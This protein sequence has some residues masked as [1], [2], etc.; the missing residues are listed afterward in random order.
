VEAYCKQVRLL[1]ERLDYGEDAK[2]HQAR[3]LILLADL[4]HERENARQCRRYLEEARQ[5]LL[6]YNG[7]D[8]RMKDLLLGW[9]AEDREA[10]RPVLDSNGKVLMMRFLPPHHGLILSENEGLRV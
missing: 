8:K 7:V 6:D 4:H 1:A 3:L 9:T 5:V 2:I 10:P